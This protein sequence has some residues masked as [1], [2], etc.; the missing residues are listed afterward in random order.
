M[1][2][3]EK[4]NAARRMLAVEY[5]QKIATPDTVFVSLREALYLHTDELIEKFLST[6]NMYLNEQILYAAIDAADAVLKEASK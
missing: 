2:K 5:L 6:K 3:E 4:L 1:T